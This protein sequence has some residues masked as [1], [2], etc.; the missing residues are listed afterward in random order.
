[1]PTE[2]EWEHAC[3]AGT[4]GSYAGNV[5]EM[6]WFEGVDLT[7]ALR[8]SNNM[9]KTGKPGGMTHPVGT[10][11]PNAWGLYDMYGN[12]SEWCQ[13]EYHATYDDAPTDGSEWLTVLR[14]RSDFDLVSRVLRGGSW[15]D[16]ASDLRSA[17]RVSRM[18]VY[19]YY[20][21]G[22]RVAAVRVR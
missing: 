21:V 6:A 1:L 10:R 12:V 15:K 17:V 2:A 13:D 18:S 16:D 19:N 4:T 11:Q 20:T 22:F 5:S 8:G 3:H 14:G 7:D 9:N